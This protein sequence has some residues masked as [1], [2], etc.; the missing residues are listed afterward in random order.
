MR[1]LAKTSW[2]ATYYGA[3]LFILVEYVVVAKVG[4]YR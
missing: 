4:G 3:L 2:L 1:R